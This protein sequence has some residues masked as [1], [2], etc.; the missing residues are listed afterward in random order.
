MDA[1]GGV[2]GA[3]DRDGLPG[4]TDGRVGDASLTQN[5]ILREA[6]PSGG[7]VDAV[8]T[9]SHGGAS[10]VVRFSR[11]PLVGGRMTGVAGCHSSVQLQ[12]AGGTYF[13]RK[14]ET[15]LYASIWFSMRAKP[16]PSS[17]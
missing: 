13:F 2:E 17:A 3:E 8:R 4:F 11:L 10:F 14:F 6:E 12:S 5:V 1:A 15:R 7:S 16:W 9:T